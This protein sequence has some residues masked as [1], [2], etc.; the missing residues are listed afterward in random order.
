[1]SKNKIDFLKILNR[2]TAAQL[3]SNKMLPILDYLASQSYVLIKSIFKSRRSTEFLLIAC[4]KSRVPL[5]KALLS[6]NLNF[7]INAEEKILN[8]TALHYTVWHNENSFTELHSA[9]EEGDENEVIRL[10]LKGANI[11]AQ[12]NNG[13]MPLH[14]ACKKGHGDIIIALMANLH[15]KSHYQIKLS[16]SLHD[17]CYGQIAIEWLLIFKRPTTCY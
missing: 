17:K 7:E 1:M 14:I 10:I 2:L 9:C 4:N 3:K 6:S 12:D 13:N 8:N 16:A 5:A 11:N 15:P